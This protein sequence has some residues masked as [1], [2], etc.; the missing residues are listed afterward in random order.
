[1][2]IVKNHPNVK[3]DSNVVTSIR[4]PVSHKNVNVI[5]PA[6]KTL[7]RS[8]CSHGMA[9]IINGKE[10]ID[11][12]CSKISVD[13]FI[14]PN[15][16]SNLSSYGAVIVEKENFQMPKQE[17]FN[18]ATLKFDSTNRE[19]EKFGVHKENTANEKEKRE[20]YDR[21]RKKV[22]ENR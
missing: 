4:I 10:Y 12:V 8:R 19:A 13:A 1:M 3:A 2:Q 6:I 21:W 7:K 11:D 14:K 9:V 16:R 20:S 5:A 22:L 17:S 18:N 15:G